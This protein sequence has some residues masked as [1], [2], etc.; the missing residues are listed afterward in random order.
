V[1][2]LFLTHYFT[3][4]NNAPAARVHGMAREWA[5]AG[6]RVTVL[7]CAPNVPSGV[8]Y[9]GYENKLYQEEWIDGIRTVR[10]W[11]W[12]AANRGRVRRGLNYLSYLAA[13]GAAG[14][15]LRP[16][17]DV[18]IATSPQFFAGWAGWPVARAHGAPFVLEI[19]DIWPDSIVAVGT[20][21]KGRIVSTLGKLELQLYDGAD[22]IVAAGDGYRMNMIR[23]GIGPSRISVV[24]NGVDTEL[25]EPRPPDQE[26]RSRLGFSAETFVITVLRERRHGAA[27]LA[28]L[29]GRRPD[30]AR[31][32]GLRHRLRAIQ[33]RGAGGGGRAA[34]RRPR[35]G[36]AAAR[37]ERPPLRPG[38]LRPPPARARLPRHPRARARRT[39]EGPP[40]N[41]ACCRMSANERPRRST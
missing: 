38:A 7:T 35:R 12:L 25:F 1:H 4:E 39:P 21:E 23:K 41:P 26:L 14:P 40:M 19:R 16:R 22:H 36:A 20:L 10:V 9:E 30:H 13:A 2:I 33:R 18:V 27:D 34:R 29:R 28:R 24:T 32:G 15:L 5:R 3:P 31:G 6:H 37:R 17:A 11:T 8:V